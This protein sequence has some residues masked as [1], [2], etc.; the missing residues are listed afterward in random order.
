[1]PR[2]RA[3][4]GKYSMPVDEPALVALAKP[5]GGDPVKAIAVHP[6]GAMPT[7]DEILTPLLD[8]CV[9]MP[10]RKRVG[11]YAGAVLL[12]A[13]VLIAG[14]RLDALSLKAPLLY[15]DDA[16]LIMPMVKA[17]LERGS[18]WRNERM[19]YPGILEMHDFPVVDHLH[20]AIIWLLG[21]FVSDWVVVYN[22]YY[23]LT[24]PLTTFTAMYAGRRL[25]LTLPMASAGGLLYAFLPYHY[26]RGEAHYFLAAY[27]LV[28][29]SWLPALA[30]SRGDFPFFQVSNDGRRRFS[31]RSRQT[32]R[33]VLLA[34]ATA[35]AGA[36][37]AFFACA[38]YAF[39]G[40][41]GFAKYRTWKSFAS[42]GAL[43]GC[44]V[45]VGILHHLPTIVYANQYGRNSVAVRY[46]EE[47]ET[48]GLKIAHLLLPVDGHNVTFIG[49]IKSGYYS[50][51]RPLNNENAT[52]TLGLVGSI[53][54]LMLLASLLF[55]PRKKW[56]FGP[57]AAFAAFNVFFATIGGFGALFNLLIF[58]QVRCLNRISIYLAYICQ[59]AV[60]WQLDR[61]LRSRIGWS[62]RL[63]LPAIAAIIIVGIFDQ[64]P[65][66][67]FG[68]RI[69]LSTN[70]EQNRFRADRSFFAEIE[71]HLQAGSRNPLDL[72]APPRVFTLPYMGFPEVPPS[73]D[74]NAYEHAR[75]YLHTQSVVWSYGAI[76]NREADAW[77]RNVVFD[78]RDQ[79][80][81]AR[82][83]IPRILYR[84]F[85][86][87][88]IDTRGF[89]SS[90]GNAGF[91]LIE[92][93]KAMAESEAHVKLPELVHYDK[94][95]VFLDLRPYR[96]YLWNLD[97]GRIFGDGVIREREWVALIWLH[98]FRSMDQST[99]HEDFRWGYE[100]GHAVI[101]NPSNR[102]RT[103]K[104]AFKVGVDSEGEFRITIDGKGLVHRDRAEGSGPLQDTFTVQK[105]EADPNQPKY[106]FGV[107]KLYVLEVPPGRHLV[108]I[109]CRVPPLFMP[110]NIP[111]YRYYIKD[112]TFK[113]VR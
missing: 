52:A 86:G 68:K 53:G 23:L 22:L 5:P 46:P 29:L 95:Q 15:D 56:P 34:A 89:L 113:E 60:L 57:L 67:W 79:K 26:M 94:R 37:Y 36:Y 27:W 14:L 64:T 109:T 9:A 65:T 6:N 59:F 88:L 72:D 13:I 63:Y 98:G 70:M 90:R 82:E 92:Q 111:A 21:R 7:P 54:F 107:P 71:N 100:V 80:T 91:Q 40:L 112:A 18:H 50:D 16:L 39:A 104:F 77:Q 30:L 99:R 35:S 38:I 24:Y 85:D 110:G 69:A 2:V 31:I 51:M 3:R 84:G 8:S 96:D 11:W 106:W 87:V 93:I 43:I 49:Q 42:S 78:E 44:V 47:A 101:I 74:L 1:M 41:F 58:D 45:A 102:T 66:P 105:P 19:G 73:F 108:E 32:W 28:P 55:S 97:Q 61:F 25:G 103:F 20:F 81:Y 75:G 48:Y 17:T 12:T 10:L 4:L 62:R 76:K 83:L 33:Q